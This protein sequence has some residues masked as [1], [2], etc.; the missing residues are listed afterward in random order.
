MLVM[1]FIEKVD[2]FYFDKYLFGR[3]KEYANMMENKFSVVKFEAIPENIELGN[4]G[5]SHSY[6]AFDVQGVDPGVVWFDFSLPTQTI[7]YDAKVLSQ[8]KGNF[9]PGGVAILP[10]SHFSLYYYGPSE[11]LEEFNKVNKRYYT[12]LDKENIVYY[13]DKEKNV[14]SAISNLLLD[15]EQL[16]G[17]EEAKVT[18]IPEVMQDQRNILKLFNLIEDDLVITVDGDDG[19]W[20]EKATEI[21]DLEEFGNE[22]FKRYFKKV[23]KSE[24]NNLDEPTKE[25]WDG[26]LEF[27]QICEEND[28]I[29]VLI[30]T[31]FLDEYNKHFSREWMNR[32]YRDIKKLCKAKGRDVI[33]LDYSKDS[34]FTYSPEFFAD[35][36]H[37]NHDGAL[38]FTEILLE[39]L[40][41]M[42]IKYK[43]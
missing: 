5:S 33:Y 17:V 21:E 4:F 13:A 22:T 7:Q 35:T 20:A 2:E 30:T 32:F 42:G 24:P 9:A 40:K 31:P 43:I 34:R 26:A 18:M 1:T 10:I 3:S 28:I 12:F 41:A 23:M 15:K 36:T 29:P 16:K 38:K 6:R 19:T 14:N 25:M 37:L 11:D 39:D 8:Y 27:L